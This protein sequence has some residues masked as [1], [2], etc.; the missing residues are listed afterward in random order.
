MKQFDV[1]VVGAGSGGI[2]AAWAAAQCGASVLLIEKCSI[3]GG[4]FTSSGVCCWEA[5]IS[6]T[7]LSELIFQKSCE[8]PEAVDIYPNIWKRMNYDLTIKVNGLDLYNKIGREIKG[9][10]GVIIEPDIYIKAVTELLKHSGECELWFNTSVTKLTTE[11]EN[12]NSIIVSRNGETEKIYGNIFIDSTGHLAIA[13]MAGC[14]LTGGAEAR[15]AYNESF[16]PESAIPERR[17]GISLIFRVTQD[18]ARFLNRPDWTLGKGKKRPHMS[19]WYQSFPNG[20]IYINPLPTF[21]GKEINDFSAAEIYK[22]GICRTWDIWEQ[23]KNANPRF[24]DFEICWIAPELGVREGKRIIAEYVLTQNDI[25]DGLGRHK[26]DDIIAVSDH[27]LDM[28]GIR[29]EKIQLLEKP[30][31]IPFRTLIPKGWKNLLIACRGAG[32]SHLAA[33]SCRLSRTIMQLGQAAG[34]AAALATKAKVLLKNL[35]Y[36][37]LQKALIRQGVVLD[38]NILEKRYRKALRES[39]AE[40]II[41]TYDKPGKEFLC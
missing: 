2:G 6:G 11:A 33:S 39:G 34:T 21:S 28:H 22:E 20:D 24:S 29:L 12:I 36:S 17:N 4:T 32:F 35:K 40:E 9:R 7:G 18:K 26:Y 8:Y 31:G 19:P 30:Y 10:Y 3:P 15:N 41:K 27:M 25:S 38:K 14:E 23:I 5:S 1:I 37:Q 13:K 16:A